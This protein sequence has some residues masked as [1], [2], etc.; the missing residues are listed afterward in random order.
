MIRSFLRAAGVVLLVIV[1]P[2]V[3][4]YLLSLYLIPTPQIAVIRIEGDIWGFYTTYITEALEEV[5]QDPAVR[6][7]VLEIVSP[8]GEVTASE[9]LYFDVLKLREKKPVIASVNELAASGAYYIACAAD[10]IYAKPASGIGNVGV[11]SFLPEPDLVDEILITTGPFKLSG[12]PQMTYIRQLE[13]LKDSFIA[14]I[15]AQREGRLNIGPDVLSRGEIYPG[16]QAQQLGLIDHIGSQGDAI[17]AAAQMAKIRHYKIVDRTPKVP[18]EEF[19]FDLEIRKSRTAATVAARP[20]HLPPGFY[21]R[22]IEP[23]Q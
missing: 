15:M 18:E 23:T 10:E 22:Y 9:T 17:I 3:L 20:K 13:M 12:G 6:G 2:L 8:G 21:Y 4:G 5:Q 1:L 14:A 7:V 11:I 16:L 19:P